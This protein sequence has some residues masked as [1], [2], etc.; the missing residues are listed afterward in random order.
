M[1]EDENEWEALNRTHWR[2]LG[3]TDPVKAVEVCSLLLVSS[4]Y[5]FMSI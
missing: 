4:S 3:L 1:D 5:A 2:G